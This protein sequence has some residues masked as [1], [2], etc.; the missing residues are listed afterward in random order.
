MTISMYAAS[1]PVFIKGLNNMKGWLH[2]AQAHAE[3]KKFDVN[4]LPGMRLAPDMLPLTAQV[5][6]ACD[7]AKNGSSRL[8]GVEPPRFEDNEKTVAELVERIEKTIGYLETLSAAQIDGTEDKD[9]VHA[10]RGGDKHFKGQAYL[11]THVLPNFWFHSTT[12]YALL[13]HNGVDLGKKDFL[14]NG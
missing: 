1:V 11:L 9:I 3:A 2:K 6:I 5:L 13:R 10:S 12:A 8:A 14:G 4:V 7:G